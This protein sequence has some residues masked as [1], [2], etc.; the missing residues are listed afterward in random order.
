MDNLNEQIKEKQS[1]KLERLIKEGLKSAEEIQ[2]ELIENDKLTFDDA[3]A[4]H[5]QQKNISETIIWLQQ[6]KQANFPSKIVSLNG[7]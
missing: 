6:V 3:K 7:K 5:R 4:M 2:Q 1:A